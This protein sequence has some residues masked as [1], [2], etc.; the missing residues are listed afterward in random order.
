VALV[1]WAALI[2][3]GGATEPMPVGKWSLVA[4]DGKALP[5][6]LPGSYSIEFGRITVDASGQFVAQIGG[7]SS[8]GSSPS[9]LVYSVGN[10]TM[11]H[12]TGTL[13]PYHEFTKTYGPSLSG[14]IRG[15][16]LIFMTR[17]FF[18][19]CIPESVSDPKGFAFVR[20][21]E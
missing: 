4:M 20:V 14:V 2:S 8:P 9:G 18:E 5:Y 3:C 1:L 19:A 21:R 7:Y 16:S 17:C 6:V 11:S 13:D 10:A 15:D 12:G